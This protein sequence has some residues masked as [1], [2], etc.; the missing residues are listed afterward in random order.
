MSIRKFV[1]Q[2]FTSC[3]KNV[4]LLFEKYDNTPK[5]KQFV[6]KIFNHI[7]FWSESTGWS[8]KDINDI[9]IT[10]PLK[11]SKG[12]ILD[13]WFPN[14]SNYWI[15]EP[16]IHNSRIGTLD[17]GIA[18]WAIESEERSF[19]IPPAS[20]LSMEPGS[21]FLSEEKYKYADFQSLRTIATRINQLQKERD[22]YS[23]YL[24]DLDLLRSGE[25]DYE[26]YK[27]FKGHFNVDPVVEEVEDGED[28]CGNPVFKTLINK[29]FSTWLEDSEVESGKMDTAKAAIRRIDGFINQKKDLYNSKAPW[30]NMAT[31][32]DWILSNSY[33][34]E[35]P[36]SHDFQNL[37][38][39]DY[40]DPNA[41]IINPGANTEKWSE[42]NPF[43]KDWVD[44]FNQTHPSLK[45]YALSVVIDTNGKFWKY[46]PI[47]NNVFATVSDFSVPVKPSVDLKD[48]K[49]IR[50]Y[51]QDSKVIWDKGEIVSVQLGYKDMANIYSCRYVGLIQTSSSGKKLIIHDT[52]E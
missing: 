47:R 36:E 50:R 38:D 48:K 6:V 51:H 2:E 52:K 40:S 10:E 24:H 23:D 4:K 1:T 11:D 7:L 30:I 35:I 14:P 17:K 22:E 18:L 37:E 15:R 29:R 45:D 42:K 20:V 49:N 12:D 13:V 9:Y 31:V 34:S 46:K 26:L 33:F 21:I 8:S 44:R 32:S 43:E 41:I 5:E 19:K 39:W 25:Q 28:S 3:G 27:D 16:Y